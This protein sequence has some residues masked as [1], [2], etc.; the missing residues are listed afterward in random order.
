[1]ASAPIA[2][3]S[4]SLDRGVHALPSRVQMPPWAAPRMI[5]PLLGRT[6]SAPTR[7]FMRP[8]TG[9][10]RV[11]SLIGLG[12]CEAQAPEKVAG[13]AGGVGL[14]SPLAACAALAR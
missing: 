5:R 10:L 12:P 11:G 4:W 1:M 14:P 13:P 8:I 2:C 6:D 9:V 3:V 7:P